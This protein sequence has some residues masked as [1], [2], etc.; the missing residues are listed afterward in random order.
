[1][2]VQPTYFFND[3]HQLV[4]FMEVW[5]SM[6][7]DRVYIYLQSIDPF[8]YRLMR[9][10]ER[11]HMLVIVKWLHTCTCEHAPSS[12]L[13]KA[14]STLSH[15]CARTCTPSELHAYDTG[16]NANRYLHIGESFAAVNDCL[17]RVRG[18]A[19]YVLASAWEL[20]DQ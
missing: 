5:R 9:M 16:H 4:Q 20:T 15:T 11:E 18:V 14:Q 3:Y 13:T 2:C 8:T 7:V 10:Y 6:G 19:Q 12:P 1:M 17:L